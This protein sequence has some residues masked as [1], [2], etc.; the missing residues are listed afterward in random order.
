M[1]YCK[2]GGKPKVLFLIEDRPD[3]F[4]ECQIQ[5]GLATAGAST[6]KQMVLLMQS[7]KDSENFLCSALTLDGVIALRNGI[8]DFLLDKIKV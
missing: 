2:A 4:V 3:L 1:E 6:S 7:L 5:M 8:D